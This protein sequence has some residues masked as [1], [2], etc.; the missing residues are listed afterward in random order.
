V[1]INSSQRKALL[2][3][4]QFTAG[5]LSAAAVSVLCAVSGCQ[6]MHHNNGDTNGNARDVEAN[7]YPAPTT[8]CCN[9]IGDGDFEVD[10]D[11]VKHEKSIG[12]PAFHGVARLPNTNH[13]FLDGYFL[14]Q[15]SSENDI[16]GCYV[17]SKDASLFSPPP[18]GYLFPFFGGQKTVAAGV[19]SISNTIFQVSTL[20]Q[21]IATKLLAGHHYRLTFSQGAF[22]S[23]GGGAV[24]VKLST[25]PFRPPNTPPTIK[26]A[27]LSRSGVPLSGPLTVK[28]GSGWTKQPVDIDSIP[29]TGYY[30]LAFSSVAGPDPAAID[31]VSLCEK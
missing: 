12:G 4:S 5:I 18:N 24:D 29:E 26:F 7:G 27:V 10:A 3:F 21:P 6:Q 25:Q 17:W 11:S 16:A 8:R 15:F 30:V 31:D 22:L 9:L 23:G 14:W 28:A 19:P 2:R 13:Q 20:S 1:T